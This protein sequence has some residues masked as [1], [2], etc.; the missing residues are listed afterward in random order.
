MPLTELTPAS[1]LP[2]TLK[3]V[4][5]HL[6][7]D[8]DALDPQIDMWIRAVTTRVQDV[9]RLQIVK[10]EFEFYVR[11]LRTGMDLPHPAVDKST[12]QVEYRSTVD[13][14][15]HSV[16][17]LDNYEVFSH[18][19]VTSLYLLS[20]MQGFPVWHVTDFPWRIR[21]EAGFPAGEVPENI[22]LYLLQLIGFVHVSP[23][24]VLDTRFRAVMDQHVDLL[25]GYIRRY[26]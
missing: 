7:I 4:K 14:E 8:S 23:Q 12:I 13:R 15:W 5:D 11:N 9:F 3:E 25:R 17:A 2:L 22:K 24:G 1:G 20:S 16:T 21:Y 18:K 26:I 6:R 10:A 19:N